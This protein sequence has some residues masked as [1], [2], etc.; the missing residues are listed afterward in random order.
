M[1]GQPW[2]H[3]D[4]RVGDVTLH[5][6]EAGAGAGRPLIV[7]L[8]GFPEFWASWRRQ[9]PAL[10]EAGF[11][12][13]VPDLRGYHRSDKPGAVAE[14]GSDRL[15]ADIAALIRAF[16]HE[17]A[18]VLG[19]DWG[20]AVAWLFA[21]RYPEALERLVIVN[22]PH[23]A[24][25]AEGLRTFRQ[26]K[27]SWYML[28]FQLPVVPEWWLSRRDF[29]ALRRML[30]ADGFTPEEVEEYVSA[31]RES[32][33]LRGPIN[34]YRAAFREL[35]RRQGATR[36]RIDA[37]TLVVWGERDRFL[38]KELAVPDPRWVPNARVAFLPEASHWVAHDAS[39]QLNELVLGFLRD[40]GER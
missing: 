2:R 26:L 35:L 22:V 39:P 5:T 29:L 37:P 23:P 1:Q 18:C 8:H 14:Y 6:V 31:A 17:R 33:R 27:K 12:V 11:H 40:R 4:V 34:Y 32:D 30:S 13:V 20:A 28:F 9:I 10:A 24:K 16:G 25:M 21:E 36:R 3:R 38:G 15:T 19:H 7:L